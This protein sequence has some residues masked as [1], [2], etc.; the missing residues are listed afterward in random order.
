MSF[1]REVKIITSSGE[2][3]SATETL[4]LVELPDRLPKLAIARIVSST[5]PSKSRIGGL[6]YVARADVPE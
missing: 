4:E 2:E 5:D 6:A 3:M 1:T